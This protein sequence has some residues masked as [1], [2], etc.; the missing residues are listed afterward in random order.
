MRQPRP[1]GGVPMFPG[2]VREGVLPLLPADGAAPP[3]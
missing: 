1:P 3:S 2:G